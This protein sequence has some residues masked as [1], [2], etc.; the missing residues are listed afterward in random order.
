MG[1]QGAR[2]PGPLRRAD[3]GTGFADSAYHLRMRSRCLILMLVLLLPMRLWA[4][5]LMSTV[6]A[7]L[8]APAQHAVMDA[9]HAGCHGHA[10]AGDDGTQADHQ[11]DGTTDET[12][13]AC[14]HCQLCHGGVM[15]LGSLVAD[16]TAPVAAHAT[17]SESPPASADLALLLKP[18]IS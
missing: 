8:Q 17:A 15:A 7:S 13:H 6:H 18:P 3:S 14:E 9:A 11:R 5:Q 16:L 2:G 1:G 4:G 12:H 10:A